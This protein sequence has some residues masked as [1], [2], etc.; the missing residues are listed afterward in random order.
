MSEWLSTYERR[1]RRRRR[2]RTA[3]GVSVAL[4]ALWAVDRSMYHWLKPEDNE[5]LRRL[6]LRDWYRT[7]RVAGTLWPWLFIT[8]GLWLHARG[9]GDE[10]GGWAAVRILAAAAAGGA[11]AEVMQMLCGRLRPSETRGEH[12]YRGLLER[13][14]DTSGLALPSS[15]A[16]VA[17]AAGYMVWF[18]YPRAG[19][20]ALAAAA[21]CGLTRML[22]GAHFASD[23]FVAGLVGYAMA[24]LLRPGGWAGPRKGL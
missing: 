23:V 3:L 6:E 17:F 24:R 2:V 10:K 14:R 12:V 18:I 21:G 22:A 16:A 9:R 5:A 19:A 11:V 13:F 1:E 8:A 15:H 4:A 7:L 20:A